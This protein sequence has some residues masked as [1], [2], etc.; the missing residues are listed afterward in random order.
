MTK[1][2]AT[3]YQFLI[4]DP[5]TMQRRK[6]RTWGTRDAIKSL[7]HEAEILEDTATAIDASALRWNGFTDTDFDPH[8]PS[9]TTNRW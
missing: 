7:K 9:A 4:I 3:V 2:I 8:K 5:A 6:A 1:V